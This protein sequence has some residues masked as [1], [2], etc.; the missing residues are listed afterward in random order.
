MPTIS[1]VLPT[2]NRSNILSRAI[3]SVLQQTIDDFELILVDDASTDD[4]EQVVYGYDDPRIT[5]LSHDDNRGGSAARNTGINNANGDF[6]AFLDS[7]DEWVPSKLEEQLNEL[8]SLSSDWVA[9]YCGY[10]VSDHRQVNRIQRHLSELLF[11]DDGSTPPREGGE[12]LIPSILMMSFPLG[13]ASNL[14]IR[15][16][17][18]REIG[19]FDEDFQRHQDYEFLIRLLKRGKLSYIDEALTIKHEYDSPTAEKV[20]LGK[21]KFFEKFRDDIEQV[22]QNGYD[23]YDEHMRQL[24]RLHCGEANFSQA[25]RYYKCF[26][27]IE[28]RVYVQLCWAAAMGIVRKIPP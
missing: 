2:Y 5:L 13:G 28:P 19:G 18:V 3:E 27:G 17:A 7:D 14:F 25:Y 24:M 4:T 22:E 15:T 10:T 20:E 26:D 12:E 9:T 16:D 11:T 23:V 21:E 8:R 1:V 6:I